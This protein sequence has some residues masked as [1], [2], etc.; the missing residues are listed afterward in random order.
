MS[1][2]L[3]IWLGL[4]ICLFILYALLNGFAAHM[5]NPEPTRWAWGF[6]W[7]A[8]LSL[9]LALMVRGIFSIFGWA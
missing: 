3:W 2:F 9:I 8:F 6:I 7:C 4:F 1:V 5:G